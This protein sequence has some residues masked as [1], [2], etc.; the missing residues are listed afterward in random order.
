[1]TSYPVTPSMGNFIRPRGKW[2]A[3]ATGSS[4]LSVNYWQHTMNSSGKSQPEVVTY[5]EKFFHGKNTALMA[6]ML[7]QP[8]SLDLVHAALDSLNGTS[9]PGI[10]GVQVS[11]STKPF[12]IS[13]APS[14][15]TFTR[16]SC[17]LQHST[18]IGRWP[19]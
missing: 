4:F 11:I 13:F 15:W 18:V 19:S 17:L 5:L 12:L 6:K 9:T 16:A 1:M 10:D 3:A 7:I 8:L 14:C 2:P